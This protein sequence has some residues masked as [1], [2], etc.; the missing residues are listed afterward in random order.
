MLGTNRV[1]YRGRLVQE[2]SAFAFEEKKR[3]LEETSPQLLALLRANNTKLTFFVTGGLYEACPDI[4]Y[5]IFDEGHEIGWHGHYHRPIMDIETLKE[6]LSA[7]KKFIC[8]F[9]PK[10]FRAPWTL[11]KESYLPILKEAGFV[12]DSSLFGPAGS[13]YETNGM[14]VFPVTSF[15]NFGFRK[16]QY[17]TNSRYI[18]GLKAFP[19]GSNFFF[20]LFRKRYDYLLRFFEKKSR[21]CIL[22][23]HSWQVFSWPEREMSLVRDKFRYVQ[24]FPLSNVIQYLLSRD[25]FLRMD[26]MLQ[27]KGPYKGHFLTFDME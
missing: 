2:D 6:E 4:V 17:T 7:S 25:A 26:T 13:Y 1:K 15:P 14:K 21:S 12:Y 8:Q 19:V 16:P 9:K 27:D 10:G 18:N 20:S 24:K 5:N 11:L 22:Y 3:H 23:I